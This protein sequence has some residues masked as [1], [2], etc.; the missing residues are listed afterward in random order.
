MVNTPHITDPDTMFATTFKQAL[1]RRGLPLEDVRDHLE[2]HGITLS[3]A[4]LSYWQS[5]RSQPEKARSLCAVDILEPFLGLPGGTLRSLLRRRP[6]GWVPPHD[7]AAVRGVYGENSDV[8][9]ALGDDFPHFNAGLRRLVVHEA[10]RVNEHRLVDEIRVTVAVRA[11]HHDA[12]HLTV[13]HTLDGAEGGATDVTVPSGPAPRTWFRPEPNCVVAEIP[14][15]RRLVR[16]ETAVVEYTVRT[17]ATAGVSHQ[18][19]SRVTTPLQ[20]YLL[21][22]R[23]HPSALPSKC[24]HSYRRRL[25]AEPGRQ[26]APLDGLHTTHLLPMKPAP[27]VHGVEWRWAD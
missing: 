19:E 20:T 7:P 5:G 2:A 25:G 27:G 13:I 10:V 17:A 26:L 9:Q 16:N 12:R 15:G 11:V 4:T 14:F 21:Q 23:F 3:V 22:V 24:W 8:E 1:Q 6:R 18:H